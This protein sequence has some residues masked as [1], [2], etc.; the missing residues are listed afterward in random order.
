MAEKY[1]PKHAKP[2]KPAGGMHAAEVATELI[3]AKHD[4]DTFEKGDA[5]NTKR[6]DGNGNVASTEPWLPGKGPGRRGVITEGSVRGELDAA[7]EQGYDPSQAEAVYNNI[8]SGKTF[9]TRRIPTAPQDRGDD[10]SRRPAL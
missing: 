10:P 9:D 3:G 4:L 5:I 7:R 8:N 6:F 2:G 1:K